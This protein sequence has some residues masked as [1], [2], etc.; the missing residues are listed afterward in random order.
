MVSLNEFLVKKHI[1]KSLCNFIAIFIE[2][3][4]DNSWDN[5]YILDS[6][7][8]LEQLVD[9]P[10]LY[11]KDFSKLT[12]DEQYFNEHPYYTINSTKEKERF[13]S[14][15]KRKN[16]EYNGFNPFNNDY[17]ITTLDAFESKIENNFVN[18]ITN[19]KSVI[20]IYK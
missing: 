3:N 14:I 16:K 4:N 18:N 2:F 7:D 8:S 13:E 17:G 1:T 20:T 9:D 5:V 10:K 6:N 12:S 19:S 11:K 15:L